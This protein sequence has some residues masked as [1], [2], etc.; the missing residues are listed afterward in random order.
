MEIVIF[1]CVSSG[2]YFEALKKKKK[3][4]GNCCFAAEAAVK[5]GSGRCN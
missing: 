1:S 4:K 2:C 5:Q 3:E